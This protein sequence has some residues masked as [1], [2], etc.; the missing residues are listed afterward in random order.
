M[1][2]VEA[3]EQFSLERFDELENMKR[4]GKDIYGQILKGDI[5]ECGEDLVDY[6]TGNNRLG[7][8]VVKVIEIK[9]D[10]S[11]K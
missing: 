7:K 9:P 8:A 1:I 6:L 2:K 11:K 4:K 5:F 10:K 3:I